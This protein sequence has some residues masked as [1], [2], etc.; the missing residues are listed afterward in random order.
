[1][2]RKRLL[3]IVVLI[4]AVCLLSVTLQVPQVPEVSYTTDF[5][6][7]I[8]VSVWQWRDDVLLVYSH[9]AGVLTDLGADWIE[10]QLGD[11]PAT[12]PAK[13]I[14]VS[15]DSGSPA[16]GWIV[17]PVEITTNGMTRAS[18]TYADD[19]T[20]QW[21]ITKSF[22]PTGTGSCQLTGLYWA[23]TGDFLLCADTFTQINYESGDTVQIRWTITVS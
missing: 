9:H 4:A 8:H 23:S 18:G 20:G 7:E 22:S 21:N 3:P 12:E 15:D 16:T 13:W 5:G 17:I 14:A 1:M 11:S 2:N 6:V 19:G 10:D